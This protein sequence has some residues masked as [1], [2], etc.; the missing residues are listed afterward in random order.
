MAILKEKQFL[1]TEKEN[2]KSNKII[3]YIKIMALLKINRK[4]TGNILQNK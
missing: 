3:K 2:L 1:K 4:K